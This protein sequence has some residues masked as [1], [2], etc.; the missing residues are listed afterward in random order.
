M[1]WA[2]D[3]INNDWVPVDLKKTGFNELTGTTREFH[4]LTGIRKWRFMPVR[5]GS[6]IPT[7]T[8]ILETEADERALGLNQFAEWP[9]ADWLTG[10]R[11]AQEDIWTGYLERIAGAITD[12]FGGTR[13]EV[14]FTI[15]TSTTPRPNKFKS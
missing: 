12:K 11:E 6:G 2:S 8:Y 15:Q 4:Q 5:D 1:E 13:T 14:E 10:A 3:V 7:N 9:L